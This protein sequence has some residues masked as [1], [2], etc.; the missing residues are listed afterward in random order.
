MRSF[1]TTD[2]IWPTTDLGQLW[3]TAVGAAAAP[4]E[5]LLRHGSTTTVA[6]TLA[7]HDAALQPQFSES[8]AA[9]P[10]APLLGVDDAASV[11][12]PQNELVAVD[13]L[14]LATAPA[15]A[16]LGEEMWSRVMDEAAIPS[17]L[18][19]AAAASAPV[20]PAPASLTHTQL[21]SLEDPEGELEGLTRLAG[22]MKRVLDEEA[23]RHGIDV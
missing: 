10:R 15:I 8:G 7:S 22:R 3:T 1:V 19:T 23:R 11:R 9:V 6:S 13:G 4:A 21:A 20:R 16:E 12:A 17:L 18:P 5:L 2:G 14:E